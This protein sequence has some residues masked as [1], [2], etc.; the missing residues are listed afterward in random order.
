MQQDP[1]RQGAYVSTLFAGIWV[2]AFVLGLLAEGVIRGHLFVP[3]HGLILVAM[4]CAIAGMNWLRVLSRFMRRKRPGTSR[5]S[6]S[7]WNWVIWSNRTKSDV[8]E[9]ALADRDYLVRQAP[10]DG[11]N[12]RLV[13]LVATWRIVYA[14]TAYQVGEY[15]GGVVTRLLK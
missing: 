1:L 4:V 12:W 8:I 3:T 13:W 6:S 7:L 14:A 5:T 2:F 11:R 15:V 10:S 9:P